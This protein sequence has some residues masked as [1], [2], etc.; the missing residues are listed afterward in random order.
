M[1][2]PANFLMKR[3][4]P[5]TLAAALMF[6]PL[7]QDAA[8]ADSTVSVTIPAFKVT[9]N[10]RGINSADLQYPLIV[11]K[12]ITYFPLTWRWCRE[13]GLTSG[14]TETDGLYI[15][16][17]IAE[18]QE[19][20]DDGGYQAADSRHT[21]VI[22]DYPVYINGR[23]IDNGKEAYPLLNFRNIT[24]FPLTWRFVADEF[25]WDQTW[26][27]ESGYKLRTS[28]GSAEVPS[29]G[30]HYYQEI[31]Y[32]LESYRDYAILEK[33]RE[34]RAI[35]AEADQHGGYS[36]N[37]VGRS[38]TRYKLDYA[39]DTLTETASEE[40]EDV[41]YLSGAA[42]GENASEWF[43][44]N[45]AALR[46]RGDTLLDLSEAAGEGNTIDSVSA[47]KYFVNGLTVYLTGVYFTQGDISV[48][49]PYTPVKFYAWIDNG[50]G[51]PQRVTSWPESQVLWAVYPFGTNGV[52]LCSNARIFGSRRLNN[53]R[54]WICAVNS[55]LSETT[56]NGRWE[57][58]NSLNAI[59]MDD[60]GGLYLLN[61]WFPDYDRVTDRGQGQVSP[62]RDGYYRL[63]PDG[64]LSKI[65]PF[66]RADEM[67]VTPSGGIYINILRMNMILHLQSGT[68]IRG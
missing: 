18:R 49:A 4:L 23:R 36:D 6:S 5:L 22:P 47:T 11:Y 53:G 14:Y 62:I 3:A 58:W 13:L 43:S 61:T 64:T 24:Y 46:F 39:T 38:S 27:S 19:I 20:L 45:G 59:G 55:D 63:A 30:T 66:I 51:I 15:A 68:K 29:P 34:E 42:R 50:G 31:F 37:Y 44:G 21:A 54:C 32:T 41:P 1:I 7:T 52:Y 67:F 28:G 56:L 16:N 10:D 48:P 57:D 25:G 9:V 17:D 12:D 33:T 60:A 8:A 40:T 65:Y 35:S 26:S 2:A